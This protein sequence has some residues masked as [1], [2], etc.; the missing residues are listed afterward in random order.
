MKQLL[1]DQLATIVRENVAEMGYFR[2]N[3]RIWIRNDEAMKEVQR[4]LRSKDS[5]N[6]T[7]WCMGR[8]SAPKRSRT[9]IDL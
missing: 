2:G 4:L 1:V 5:H 9:I 6:V 8:D 3:K 7:L